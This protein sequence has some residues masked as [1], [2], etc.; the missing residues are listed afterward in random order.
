[1]FLEHNGYLCEPSMILKF[2]LTC[3]NMVYD[4]SRKGNNVQLT[5]QYAI[6]GKLNSIKEISCG[7]LLFHEKY[8][9]L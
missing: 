2:D 7:N 8:Y 9:A 1:M 5:G 6:D 4:E 3:G